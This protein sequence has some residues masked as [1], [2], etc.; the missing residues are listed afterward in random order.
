MNTTEY[1]LTIADADGNR[2]HTIAYP[3][4]L[5]SDTVPG[6]FLQLPESNGVRQWYVFCDKQRFWSGTG[7][8]LTGTIVPFDPSTMTEPEMYELRRK[9][10]TQMGWI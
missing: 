7:W 5:P 3:T 4:E 1:H 8:R 10:L 9:L 2:L 6:E